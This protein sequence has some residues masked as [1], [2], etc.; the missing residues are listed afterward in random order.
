MHRGEGREDGS[1]DWGD[2]PTGQGWPATARPRERREDAASEPPGG[3]STAD[4]GFRTSGLQ[5][6]KRTN[7]C[8]FSLTSPR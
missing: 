3:A 5:T 6:I 8:C 4:T 1:R 7:V 2:M